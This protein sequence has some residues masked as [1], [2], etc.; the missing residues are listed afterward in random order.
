MA[1]TIANLILSAKQTAD[2]V[3][4]DQI[5]DAE[6]VRHIRNAIT[7]LH[8]WIA[9]AY[10]DT[11]FATN[12]FTITGSAYT[13]NLATLTPAF[14]RVKGV[15]SDPDTFNRLALRPFNFQERAAYM[16]Y[17]LAWWGLPIKAIPWCPHR[18]Y[19]VLGSTLQIQP[20]EIA[21]G[22]YRLYYVPAPTLPTGPSDSGWSLDANLERWVEYL[23]LAAG[24]RGLWREESDTRSTLDV[25][26]AEMRQDMLDDAQQD[27][28]PLTVTDVGWGG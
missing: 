26:L 17:S 1:V 9:N 11:F 22:N 7:E 28:N 23:E 16:G 19:H 27:E 6:W 10:R 20:Q 13:L 4:D 14:R 15:D 2:K 25:R 18:R 24:R 5:D 21:S 8:G 3:N 12:D